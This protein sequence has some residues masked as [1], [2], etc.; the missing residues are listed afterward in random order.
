MRLNFIY[1]VFCVI[2]ANTFCMN[3]LNHN[4]ILDNQNLCEN[5]DYEQIEK[6]TFRYL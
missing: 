3:R 6:E 1:L 4:F 2:T 5:P